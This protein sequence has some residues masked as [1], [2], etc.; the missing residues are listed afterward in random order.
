MNTAL[1]DTGDT[2]KGRAAT[3]AEGGARIVKV[4]ERENKQAARERCLFVFHIVAA[5]PERRDERH[6]S[7]GVNAGS[8]RHFVA[9]SYA[10][11]I[12]ISL[13]SSNAR[14]KMDIPAGS[15]LPRV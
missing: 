14:P 1:G 13:P 6:F 11:A 2:A 5:P 12:L 9:C 8:F 7:G 3:A 15:V 10:Y 4:G